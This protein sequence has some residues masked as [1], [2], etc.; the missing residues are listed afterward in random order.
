MVLEKA[1]ARYYGSFGA[2][3]GGFVHTALAD[4]VPG[5]VGELITMTNTKVKADVLSGALW[6][7]LMKYVSQG[8]LLGVGS[9]GTWRCT[10]VGTHMHTHS[11]WPTPY[12]PYHL[13]CAAGSDT[14]TSELGIVQGHAY[15]V[16][17]ARAASDATGSYQLVKLRNPWGKTEWYVFGGAVRWD[18][19]NNSCHSHPHLPPH[20]HTHT[21]NP[22]VQDGRVERL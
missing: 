14:I 22:T 5:S 9:P 3:V 12:L 8:Y 13:Q 7:K 2:I 10:T 17:D 20:T 4:F 19:A 11:S 16:L 1:Y 15:A 18:R 6:E 21:P